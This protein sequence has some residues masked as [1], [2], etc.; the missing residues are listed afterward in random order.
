M[1]HSAPP[2]ILQTK[3]DL[4]RCLE[5]I[6]AWF[7]QSVLDRP[8][9]RFYKH[10]AQFDAGELLDRARWDSLEQARTDGEKRREA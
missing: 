6:E 9:I 3:P 8:P 4:G 2:A 10:N 5:C 1:I 7:H